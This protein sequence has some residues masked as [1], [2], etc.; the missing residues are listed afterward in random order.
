MR[1]RQIS[2][3]PPAILLGTNNRKQIGIAIEIGR[4]GFEPDSDFDFDPDEI[5]FRQINSG[6]G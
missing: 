1:F 6:D 5:K 2:H 4:E 3:F